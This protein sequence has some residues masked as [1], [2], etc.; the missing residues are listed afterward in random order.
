M[1]E[2]TGAEREDVPPEHEID[3]PPG[4]R[5]CTNVCGDGKGKRTI[6]PTYFSQSV[7]SEDEHHRFLEGLQLY[8]RDWARVATHIGSCVHI[9][10]GT[11]WFDAAASVRALTRALLFQKIRVRGPQPRSAVST[12]QPH[13]LSARPL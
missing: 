13:L 3:P 5:S 10:V 1:A 12:S 8:Q 2:P 11:R 4:K 6:S 9:A 7:W